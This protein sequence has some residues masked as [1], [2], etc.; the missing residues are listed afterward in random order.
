MHVLSFARVVM[1]KYRQQHIGIHT[2]RAA[3]LLSMMYETCAWKKYINNAQT[4]TY[5]TI[6]V[7]TQ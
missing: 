5:A 4:Y 3:R 1:A 7:V 2:S 6:D